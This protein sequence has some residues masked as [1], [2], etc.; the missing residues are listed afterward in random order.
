MRQR[1]PGCWLLCIEE[2]I[3]AIPRRAASKP[4]HPLDDD[5]ADLDLPRVLE[6]PQ[7]PHVWHLSARTETLIT[8]HFLACHL[9]GASVRTG[10]AALSR[11]DTLMGRWHS[12]CITRRSVAGDG[13]VFIEGNRIA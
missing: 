10:H 4:A 7:Q 8:Q 2:G 13:Q 9:G 5:V 12:A 11:L 3:W 6:V 1:R